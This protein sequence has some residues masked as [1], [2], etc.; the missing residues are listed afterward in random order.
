LSIN[1]SQNRKVKRKGWEKKQKRSEKEGNRKKE[2]FGYFNK[3]FY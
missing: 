2:V 3:Y 1:P